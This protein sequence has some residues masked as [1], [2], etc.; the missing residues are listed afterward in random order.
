MAAQPEDGNGKREA[1]YTQA[2]IESIAE[3]VSEIK[4]SVR[5]LVSWQRRVD[6]KIAQMEERHGRQ[7]GLNAVYA[8][9]A[10]AIAGYFG[11]RQQ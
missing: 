8:T 6:A 7:A 10:A 5:D 9:V 3:D 1:G 2:K 11:T 4:E